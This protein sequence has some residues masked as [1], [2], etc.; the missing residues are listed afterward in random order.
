MFT[1]V[2]V[3]QVEGIMLY[4]IQDT[5]DGVLDIVEKD[6]LISF[7]RVGLSINGVQPNRDL[8][9][10]NY[11][12]DYFF[13]DE[14]ETSEYDS[15]DSDD[16]D[17]DFDFSYDDED[18]DDDEDYVEDDEDEDYSDEEGDSYDEDD[19]DD[20]YYEDEEEE[21]TVSKLYSYLNPEQIKTLQMYYLWY[22]QRI[23]NA[24]Q[25][26]PTLN[27]Q[28]ANRRAQKIAELN[29]L[30]N[31]GGL[32][33]YAGF[34][35]TGR[36]GGGYC[37]LG[38]KLRYMHLA[39]DVTVSDI[40]TAFWGNDYTLDIDKIISSNNCIVFGIKC[41]TDFFEVDKKCMGN[42]QRA[43]R[44][45][46]KEMD[47]LCSLYE[48]GKVEEFSSD[49]KLFEEIMNILVMRCGRCK[50]AGVETPITDGL[51]N[52]YLKFKECG[53]VYPKSLV[54]QVR[55]DLV[56]WTNHKYIGVR[57]LDT[58]ILKKASVLIFG[59]KVSKVFEYYANESEFKNSGYTYTDFVSGLRQ[60]IEMFFF[61]E[62]CGAYRYNPSDKVFKDEGG[63]SQK[64]KDFLDDRIAVIN[65]NFFKGYK[66][67]IE[68]FNRVIDAI[69]KFYD[70]RKDFL[71][72]LYYY[73][74]H[75]DSTTNICH[76]IRKDVDINSRYIDSRVKKS[77]EPKIIDIYSNLW[78][79][80]LL[81]RLYSLT[82][83]SFDS[84][85]EAVDKQSEAIKEYI[86]SKEFLEYQEVQ[87]VKLEADAENHN[88][89]VTEF[90][91][92]S[93]IKESSKADDKN[94]RQKSLDR[95]KEESS[96]N[97]VD[98][99]AIINTCIKSLRDR[100]SLAKLNSVNS[101]Y[102]QVITTVSKTGKASDK[103]MYYLSKAYEILTGAK[104]EL[105]SNGK[106]LLAEHQEIALDIAKIQKKESELRSKLGADAQKYLDIMNSILKY[107]AASERQMKYVDKAKEILRL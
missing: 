44:E 10:F 29:N 83:E 95:E 105:V 102:E 75:I 64:V 97:N 46:M 11:S 54:Q 63:S 48:S 18:D 65:K 107:G 2:G 93:K 72:N 17:D 70:I 3:Q 12:Q 82:D 36:D 6:K 88:R 34:I 49:F 39:W 33:H 60:Y 51:A 68:Y 98:K 79:G 103:Q 58:D 31:L 81:P 104:V 90:N 76:V 7:L 53:L 99:D 55:D 40:D 1:L 89:T 41:I 5:E 24:A 94:E 100:D 66:Y 73:S 52:F 96:Q 32:W 84:T 20:F 62:I 16:E 22:S 13:K 37:T 45:S 61:R 67:S 25:S 87:K 35:D 9:D 14:S 74:L 56:G 23:F 69:T 57:L 42:L 15:E 106:K 26:D 47:F 91:E 101:F 30:R 78:R 28:D 71:S 92:K 19:Y 38:H 27:M 8:T 80:R 50:L 86:S 21:S 4:A 43:Q 77:L 85:L 59:D